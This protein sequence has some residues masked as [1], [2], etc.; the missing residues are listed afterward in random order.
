MGCVD[1]QLTNSIQINSVLTKFGNFWSF[2]DNFF[3]KIANFQKP[4]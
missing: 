1:G 3:Q 4:N 2:L